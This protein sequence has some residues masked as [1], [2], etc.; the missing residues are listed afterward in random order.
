MNGTPPDDEAAKAREALARSQKHYIRG[1]SMWDDVFSR[2]NKIVGGTEGS[3]L[4]DLRKA[5]DP[6][7]NGEDHRGRHRNQD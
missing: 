7:D 4:E 5:Y 6:K 2:V 1:L 3:Y